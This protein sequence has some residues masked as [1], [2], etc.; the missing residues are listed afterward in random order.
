MSRRGAAPDLAL[1]LAAEEAGR[2]RGAA[3]LERSRQLRRFY[4]RLARGQVKP[5]KPRL[6]RE[7]RA[8]LYRAAQRRR[9]ETLAERNRQ[10]DAAIPVAWR[11]FAELQ[12]FF[13]KGYD[14]AEARAAREVQHA[15][16]RAAVANR[17]QQLAAMVEKQERV[18]D[19]AH[20]LRDADLLLR[21]RTDG[22]WGANLQTRQRFM[23]FRDRSG[24]V[25]LDPSESNR[26]TA[27]VIRRVLPMLLR[28]KSAGYLIY[29]AVF[30]MPNLPLGRLA[31]GKREIFRMMARAL[32]AVPEVVGRFDA[33]EDP[34]GKDMQS[35]N[36][37]V[38]SLLIVDPRRCTRLPDELAQQHELR[39]PGELAVLPAVPLRDRAPPGTLSYA[40]LHYLWGG[41]QVQLRK[42][43]AANGE[44]L[45]K[46][47]K[48]CLK[49]SVKLVTKKQLEEMAAVSGAATDQGGGA[50]PGDGDARAGGGY[51]APVLRPAALELVPEAGATRN[52]RLS[53]PA[54]TEWPL[55]CLDEWD[56]ANRGRRRVRT[57][58]VLFRLDRDDPPPDP[59]KDGQLRFCG[60]VKISPSGFYVEA[61]RP[62]HI[63]L[64]HG[65]K[66]AEIFAGSGTPTGR[67]PG[68][69]PRTWPVSS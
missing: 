26:D 48:E 66:S 55:P 39:L 16:S 57:F 34:L 52:R 67:S 19:A 2:R 14:W 31:W 60:R 63:D 8:E 4:R 22:N 38:N 41:N 5:R 65:D 1:V 18:T 42:L 35:W 47:L 32:E 13:D 49:Y 10:S 59:E 53:A 46:S 58:G 54:L 11:D 37:H 33:Q 45:A 50:I 61:A 6:S 20:Y 25:R 17:Y 24:L 12:E 43:E 9:L 68:A 40:K 15:R 23:R 62:L 44:L 56:L 36:V 7:E 51:R 30:S 3:A 27:R 64:I 21:A 69:Q 28:L 29:S